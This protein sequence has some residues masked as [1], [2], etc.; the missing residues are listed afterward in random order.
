MKLK[1]Q[2]LVG[3]RNKKRNIKS[4]PTVLAAKAM[5]VMKR[6]L[7]KMINEIM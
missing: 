7:N 3:K 4:N 1:Y 2:N 5:K 6:A